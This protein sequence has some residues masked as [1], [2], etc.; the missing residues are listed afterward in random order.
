VAKTEYIINTTPDR[1]FAVLSDGWTYSDWVVGTAHIRDVDPDYPIP[2]TVIHHKVGPWPFSL[3]DSTL[4]LDCE[5]DSMLLLRVGLWP[6]GEGR[7]RFGLTPI[8]ASQTRVTMIEHFP[9]GPLQWL[10]N[11]VNDIAL[12]WRN[13]ES[14]RRLADL[15]TRRESR[16]A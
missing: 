9:E 8:G 1:V 11:R 13:K 5:Q 15:A 14:L 6:L 12:H 16:R 3:K 7:V 2:G 4:V 10:Q